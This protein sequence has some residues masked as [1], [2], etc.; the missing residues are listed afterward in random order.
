M[1]RVMIP[2]LWCD[3]ERKTSRSL[4]PG[5][6]RECPECDHV[7]KGHGWDGIDAHWKAKHAG[8]SDAVRG[9]LGGDLEL[10]QASCLIAVDAAVPDLPLCR[11]IGNPDD[12]CGRY[13]HPSKVRSYA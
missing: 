10:P 12:R 2:C 9:F 5:H 8:H 3:A 7:F 13:F 1:I 11:F 4:E 6:S